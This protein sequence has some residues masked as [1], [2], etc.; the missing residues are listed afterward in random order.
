MTDRQSVRTTE[1]RSE[2]AKQGE[3]MRTLLSLIVL[4]IGGLGVAAGPAPDAKKEMAKMEGAWLVVEYDLGG[5]KLP[6]EELKGMAVVIQ[7]GKLTFKMKGNPDLIQ[8][9]T[10]D[11]AKTPKVMDY[12]FEEDGKKTKILAI[13]ELVGDQ[14][15]ICNFGQE[16]NFGRRP[17]KFEAKGEGDI[18]QLLILKRKK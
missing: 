6:P 9:L 17:A 14:L 3:K 4:G 11:P 10:I 2:L 15:K 5:N 18:T 13:Y 8:T 16:V 1:G 7:G 12:T